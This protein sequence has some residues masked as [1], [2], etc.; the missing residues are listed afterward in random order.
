MPPLITFRTC[1]SPDS[2]FRTQ[3]LFRLKTFLPIVLVLNLLFFRYFS[4]FDAQAKVRLYFKH[5]YVVLSFLDFPGKLLLCGKSEYFSLI[6]RPCSPRSGQF[7]MFLTYII[8]VD[9]REVL[10]LYFKHTRAFVV[11]SFS[12]KITLCSQSE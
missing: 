12:R 7:D 10:R 11:F 9:K 1:L 4:E 5:I 3:I 6:S 2:D 8:K